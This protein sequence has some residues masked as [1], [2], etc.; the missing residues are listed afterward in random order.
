MLYAFNE[1]ELLVNNEVN[2]TDSLEYLLDIMQR[3]ETYVIQL[4]SHTD[5]RG[6]DAYNK[7]L[8][9]RRAQT[10]VDYLIEAGIDRERLIAVGRGEGM[11]LVADSEINRMETEEEK[12]RAHQANRR[13]VFRIMRFD[14]VP[15]E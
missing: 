13:T 2:G 8:S 6:K 14:Y 9:Q 3:N 4:E 11:L 12:E 15:G 7:E 1:A 10:C 5:S